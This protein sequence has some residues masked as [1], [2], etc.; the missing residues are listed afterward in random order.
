M[1]E[2]GVPVA[3]VHLRVIGAVRTLVVR[4]TVALVPWTDVASRYGVVVVV[5][6]VI[7]EAQA[8]ES[9]F[10]ERSVTFSFVRRDPAVLQREEFGP[11]HSE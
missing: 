9:T 4:R 11:L 3:V 7:G 6:M 5:P 2:L 10:D 1:V 8:L